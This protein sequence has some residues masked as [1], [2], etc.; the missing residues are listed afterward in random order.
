M[1]LL[2]T[3][4]PPK[5]STSASDFTTALD[6]ARRWAPE[7]SIACT[8]VGNPTGIE[9]MAVEMHSSRTVSKSWPRAIPNTAMIATASHATDPNTLVIPSSSL[10][11]G[12]FCRCVEVTM[13]AIRPIS[14]ADAVAVT[15]TVAV[16]RVTCV[17][18]NTRFVR[19]LS[20]VSAS[21]TVAP[22]LATGALSPVRAASWSSSVAEVT[23]RPSAG[24]TSPASSSTTSP[25]TSLVESS[26]STAPPRRTRA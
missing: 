10:C 22:S 26:S 24:T 11:S 8:N 3:V 21:S 2:I 6:S 9:A 18:W 5:V 13:S 12:D 14:V 25:G 1:S 4:V 17:F 23:I 15:T 7:D 19:S 20:S 16:P